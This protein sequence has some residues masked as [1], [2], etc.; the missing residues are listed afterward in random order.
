VINKEKVEDENN[1]PFC[2]IFKENPS[3]FSSQPG[4]QKKE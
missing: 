1:L 4:Q 2:A 3:K